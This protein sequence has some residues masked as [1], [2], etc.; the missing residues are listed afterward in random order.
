MNATAAKRETFGFIE[1]MRGMAAL[2]VVLTHLFSAF[3]PVFAGVGGNAH[4]AWEAE[5]ARTPLYFLIDGNTAV[6]IFFL[7]SGFVLAPSFLTTKLGA[8][9]IIAKRFA[10]LYIPV[11]AAGIISVGLWLILPA[12]RDHAVGVTMSAWASALCRNPMS[13][14]SII[15]DTTLNSMVLGYETESVLQHIPIVSSLIVG[16]PL[17]LAFNPPL[18][19]LHAELWGS[20]LTIAVAFF[21]KA[22]SRR[23][24]WPVCL[25]ALLVTGTSFF[26]L[27]LLGFAAYVSKERL[28]RLK[29]RGAS[30]VAGILIACGITVSSTL[31]QHP[32]DVALNVANQV[33]WLNTRAGIRLQFEF[34]AIL[35]MLGVCLCHQARAALS[36]RLPVWLGKISFSLYLIH[37]PVIFTVGFAVF[38]AVY[39]TFGYGLS[40]AFA[41]ATS[42]AL[43][44]LLAIAFERYVDARSV[45]FSRK[46]TAYMSTSD[47][48]PPALSQE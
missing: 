9:Q 18:W 6:Y 33:A 46:L 16:T 41:M 5:F 42:M 23:V 48:S 7:M 27:F 36:M 32:F 3:F 13:L 1:G 20:V 31:S 26:T 40:A 37:F 8:C 11:L 15:K 12:A 39:P 30:L 29:S 45:R 34:G 22:V 25:I 24:F 43:S 28:V 38:N 47:K 44:L 21:Y 14:W 19:T 35:I 4:Y 2:Q 17:T 10:R